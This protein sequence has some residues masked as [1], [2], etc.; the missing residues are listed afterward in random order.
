MFQSATIAILCTHA[1]GAATILD[2]TS[3]QD[4]LTQL[5]DVN[6]KA[7]KLHDLHAMQSKNIL[8]NKIREDLTRAKASPLSLNEVKADITTGFFVTK[9]FDPTDTTCTETVEEAGN[10]YPVANSP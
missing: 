2:L 6:I 4:K 10:T 9:Y 3:R 8:N 7:I 5:H 1:V